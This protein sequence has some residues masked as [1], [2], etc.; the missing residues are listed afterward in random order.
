MSTSAN[1]VCTSFSVQRRVAVF[2]LRSTIS[3][4][5]VLRRPSDEVSVRAKLC[6]FLLD[7]T[8]CRCVLVSDALSVSS[9]DA[10]HRSP[11]CCSEAPPRDS[12]SDHRFSASNAVIASHERVAAF[13]FAAF[14]MRSAFSLIAVRTKSVTPSAPDC[15]ASF[16]MC[17][18]S[19][20]VARTRID[21]SL[22]SLLLVSNMRVDLLDVKCDAASINV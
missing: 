16:S 7:L 14:D 4:C 18:F 17:F 5:C 11:E 9:E 22:G 13:R 8:L 21:L 12:D 6:R 19:A 1:Q 10:R 15:R 2:A 3:V 20:A